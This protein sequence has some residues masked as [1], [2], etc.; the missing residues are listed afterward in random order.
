MKFILAPD[1]FKGSLTGIEFCNAVEEGIK[2]IMPEAE[3]VKM[4]LADGGDGIIEILNYHLN[5]KR[6][7]V[8]VNDPLF[9]PVEA[10][11][12]YIES[13]QTAFIEM[14]EAS[15]IKLLPIEKQNC[16]L[17]STFGTGEIIKQAIN[18]GVKTIVLG[19]GG[20]ATN[21][22]GIGMACALGYQFLDKNG[23]EVIPIGK[24][25]SSINKIDVSNVNEA[26]KTVEFK[27][28]CD[29][30]NP[31]YGRNG[32]AYVYASQKGA[33]VD[34]INLLNKGLEHFSNVLLEY[35]KVDV[36]KIEGSG[37]AGGMGAGALVFLNA[38]LLSGIDLV[39]EVINFDKKIEGADWIITGEGNL[40]S[41]TF[42]GK[43]IKGVIS[44]AKNYN[45]NVAALCGSISLSKE[46]LND[47]GIIYADSIINLASNLDDAMVNSYKYLAVISSN[48]T[49][50][51]NT[52][53]IFKKE[54]SSNKN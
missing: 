31:L 52:S 4:P 46:S 28:A 8:T 40:D 37:A 29:V 39:K 16:F 23:N 13:S 47:L 49:E 34:E 3:I 26:L 11:Y 15:G 5:G 18:K 14:A 6:L 9:K 27:V 17:T 41:Q 10:S 22:C 54:K 7:T 45:I 20:S 2:S 12:L 32:A 21:D 24:N 53:S 36:Q 19:I 50:N 30:T 48:F 33:S 38:N 43:T 44:S 1:K 42:S 35:F 25:L 51:I